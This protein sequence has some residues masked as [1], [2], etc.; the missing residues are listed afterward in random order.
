[1]TEIVIETKG[2]TKRYGKFPAVD[3]LDLTIRQ[4]EVFGLL[5]PNGAG[6]TTTI[7]LLLGLTEPTGGSVKVLGE[8]P[9]RNPLAVKKRVGYL[10]DAVGFYDGMTARENLSYTAR[11]AG[12]ARPEAQKRID[13]A[14][15]TVR[16]TASRNKRVSTFSRGM[17]Q[18]LGIADLL[19]KQ[20][21]LA[22][23]DEPTSGLDPQ[24]T[25][26]LLELIQKLAREGMTIVLSSH[27]LG[28]VQAICSRVA[29][30]NAGKAAL[31]G[32]V[33]ELAGQVLGGS[34]IIQLEADGCNALEIAAR[35]EGVSQVTP[36]GSGLIRIDAS[37][38]VRSA[39]AE[40]I[41]RA[42]GALK[43][44]SMDRS[45]LDEVYVRYFEQ[46]HHAA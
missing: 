38:D 46:V 18:R 31:V 12:I 2:L 36:S 27:L 22:I 19:V 8:D 7:L 20:C 9:L 14:L 5:G 1:M 39:V 45:S 17:R 24:S 4:G 33:D 15:E 23:L 13:K 35:V 32:R 6:K 43:Q 10:P 26:E 29:L 37:H 25:Q 21:E 42:G 11:L 34:Y 30:F 41:V 3:G 28:M 40:A 16:L 44:M